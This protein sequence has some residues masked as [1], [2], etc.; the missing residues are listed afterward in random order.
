VSVVATPHDASH[1]LAGL[2]PVMGE[3]VD[4]FG[5]CRLG[6]KPAASQRFETLAN[7]IVSQQLAGAAADTIWRRLRAAVGPSFTPATVCA[8]PLDSLRG[9]GLSAAKAASIVDLAQ[10]VESCRHSV[11]CPTSA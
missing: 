5:P 10:R 1:H 11:D 7:A 6:T 8:T 4:R 3:L 9:A 2:H